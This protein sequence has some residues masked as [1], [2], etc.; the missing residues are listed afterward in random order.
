MGEHGGN[1]DRMYRTYPLLIL[2]RED[3]RLHDGENDEMRGEGGG[4]G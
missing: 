2:E 3:I 4:G 1:K